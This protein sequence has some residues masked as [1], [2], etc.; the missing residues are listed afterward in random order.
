VVVGARSLL[1]I[2]CPATLTCAAPPDSLAQQVSPLGPE[3][4]P[5]YALVC[6]P[7]ARD[8]DCAGGNGNGPAYVRGPVQIVGEDVY[9]LDRDGDGIACEPTK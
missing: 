2:A 6:V 5:N 4:H 8:V 1:G 7:I 9:E 3:C